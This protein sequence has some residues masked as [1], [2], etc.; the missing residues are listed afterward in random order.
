MSWLAEAGYSLAGSVALVRRDPDAFKYFN[1]T[2]AGFWRSFGAI[3]F[4]APLYL[5]AASIATDLASAVPSERGDAQMSISPARELQVLCAHWL[6]WPLLMAIICRFSGLSQGYAR[7]I[8]AFNWC[9]V[10]IVSAQLAPLL[11]Y[12]AGLFS[13]PTTTIVFWLVVLAAGYF[14]WYFSQRALGIAGLTA[15]A[16]VLGEIALGLG[17][18]Q[19]LW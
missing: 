8:I 12:R 13:A 11:L 19:L 2:E 6:G 3:A 14:H 4:V 1:E 16:I 15:V 5:A 7:Y 17:L 18:S 10:L 9:S